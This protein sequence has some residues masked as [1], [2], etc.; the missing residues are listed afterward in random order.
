MNRTKIPPHN[1]EAEQALLGSMMLRKEVVPHI[2]GEVVPDDFYSNKHG[3]IFAAINELYAE[4][5][6]I[7]IITV[8]ERSKAS[9]CLES[10]GGLTYLASLTNVIPGV[11]SAKDFCTIVRENSLRRSL[12]K[13]AN[14][15]AEGGYRG[16]DITE[17]TEAAMKIGAIAAERT[18]KGSKPELVSDIADRILDEI[19]KAAN[20]DEEYSGIPTGIHDIDKMLFGLQPSDLI[21]LAARPS[22]GKTTFGLNIALNAAMNGVGVFFAS[23]EMS[24]EQLVKKILSQLSGVKHQNLV[25]G[26]I[27]GDTWQLVDGGM[28]KLKSS[29]GKNLVIDDSSGLS[30]SRL[31]G[32]AKAVAMQRNIGLIVVDYL[33]LMS[34]KAES[35]E[36]EI[37][38][39]SAGL[40][41]LAKDLNVP[42]LALSQLNRSLENRQ[43]KRPQMSDLRDSGA[44][45]QDADVI[46]FLYRDEYYNQDPRN[47]N[48][49]IAECNIA[50]HRNGSTG[51]VK[52]AF[53][54]A[55]SKFKNLEVLH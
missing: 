53:D 34:G 17:L 9:G 13:V 29:I 33:Q 12:I 32:K 44:I 37:A 7:D 4:G 43:E 18:N 54:P 52:M 14:D 38:Q 55:V 15:V 19:R 8:G 48:K 3:L 10:I 46:M 26:R 23:M 31:N 39:I 47:P 40:K 50:K 30:I 27:Y 16:A 2:I 11:T 42:V 41:Q 22:M 5:Q 21:I 51:V 24:K 1:I 36:R 20:S 35:R 45:E 49:G 25:R 6:S 28:A